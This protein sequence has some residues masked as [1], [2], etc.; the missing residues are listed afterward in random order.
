MLNR[1]PPV[2]ILMLALTS[3]ALI[4]LLGFLVAFGERSLQVDFAAF[5]T[6]GEAAS[7]GVSP[8]V[9]HYAMSPPI[10]DGVARYKHSRFLYPPLVATFF[11]SLAF[12]PYHAAKYVW[13]VANVVG[14]F[15]ALY[16][17]RR[18]SAV[19]APGGVYAWLPVLLPLLVF[20]PLLTLLERGQV[21]GVSL[22]LLTSA[23]FLISTGKRQRAAGVLIAVASI[24][25]LHT[26]LLLPI[27][28][29]RRQWRVLGG[30]AAGASCI[31]ALS[32]LVCGPSMLM[33]YATVE[34]PRIS[35]FAENGTADMLAD[36]SVLAAMRP[37]TALTVKDGRTYSLTRFPFVDNASLVRTELG[38]LVRRCFSSLGLPAS[39]SAVS[40]LVF[41]G[42]FG[43]LAV[44]ERRA[45]S[46]RSLGPR[47]EF[48]YWQFALVV[49]L[50]SAPL[51]WVMNTSWLVTLLP[52]AVSGLS[53]PQSM[54]NRPGLGFA[55]VLLGLVAA[56]IPD[57][58]SFQLLFPF[59]RFERF[60]GDY[61]YVL[62]EVAIAAGLVLHL[63]LVD[64]AQSSPTRLEAQR[65]HEARASLHVA[66]LATDRVEPGGRHGN[67]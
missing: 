37:D 19:G 23:I 36:A 1:A 52:F 61:K 35:T 18:V 8:Y 24:L 13:M 10:W 4:R 62:A 9:N 11:Q 59:S 28:L 45:P 21:D 56:A 42:F 16:L 27:L 6:A 39:I 44:L 31:V 22:I 2:N 5:Y 64:R 50:L 54:S 63:G 30:Y 67:A 41:T 55:L 57:H 34:F 47:D 49:I 33:Q 12:L 66:E 46:V 15:A 53:G 26:V 60:L 3:F 48:L 14:V 25:K 20:H 51:T 58:L 65:G 29:L 32:L 43:L 17:A 40:L 7:A 38:D